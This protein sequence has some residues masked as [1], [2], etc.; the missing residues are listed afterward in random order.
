MRRRED[1]SGRKG[2]ATVEREKRG[3]VCSVCSASAGS[4][5]AGY[6]EKYWETKR[7]LETLRQR[8]STERDDELETLRAAKKKLEKKVWRE[9]REGGREGRREGGREGERGREGGRK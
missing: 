1:E 5:P 2:K 9:G 8:L 4:P 7:E 3:G 6:L